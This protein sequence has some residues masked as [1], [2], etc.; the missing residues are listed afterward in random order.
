MII[1]IVLALCFF[2]YD[3]WYVFTDHPPNEHI[4]FLAPIV[5]GVIALALH[6][7]RSLPDGSSLAPRP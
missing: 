7:S 1:L 3:I 4:P 6:W 5:I 2:G